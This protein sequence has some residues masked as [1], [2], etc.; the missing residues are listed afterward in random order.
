M[1]IDATNFA[2]EKALGKEDK[3]EI[4]IELLVLIAQNLADIAESQAKIARALHSGVQK[5]R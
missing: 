3:E 1:S 2:I 4:R 5:M